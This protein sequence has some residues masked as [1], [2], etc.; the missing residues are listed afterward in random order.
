SLS[1]QAG[2]Q[3]GRAELLDDTMVKV[4]NKANNTRHQEATTLLFEIA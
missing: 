4:L 1:K 3:V 2:I